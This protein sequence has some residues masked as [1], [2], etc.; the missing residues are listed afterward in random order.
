MSNIIKKFQNRIQNRLENGKKEVE[1]MRKFYPDNLEKMTDDEKLK[2]FQEHADLVSKKLGLKRHYTVEIKEL[3]EKTIGCFYRHL[4]TDKEGAIYLNTPENLKKMHIDTYEL[5]GTIGHE[6]MHARQDEVIKG[7]IHEKD[8]EKVK[9]YMLGFENGTV[10]TPMEYKGYIINQLE[11]KDSSF[12]ISAPKFQDRHSEYYDLYKAQLIER[13]AFQYG[14][15]LTT[16]LYNQ[17]EKD[18]VVTL[19]IKQNYEYRKMGFYNNT[20]KNLENMFNT[21]NIEKQLDDTLKII[22]I[23]NHMI[24]PY[25]QNISS[26]NN[27]LNLAVRMNFI[28]SGLELRNIEITDPRNRIDEEIAKAINIANIKNFTYEKTL[29]LDLVDPEKTLDLDLVDPEKTL[30]LDLVDKDEQNT[31]L[32]NID[33]ST[34][35]EQLIDFS[36]F[37]ININEDPE[38]QVELQN[39][40]EN[41]MELI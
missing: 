19:E 35:A 20:I 36:N 2:L 32:P 31:N 6:L 33:P 29:D 26:I 16:N 34:I 24:S 7:K 22:A 3:E 14:E 21:S 10:R 27:E 11:N 12:Y 5:Y 13:E 38:I 8:K 17:M 40:D 15:Q 9:L 30:D 23:E 25:N 4:N 39:L 18:K 37:E 41:E 1:I 28:R